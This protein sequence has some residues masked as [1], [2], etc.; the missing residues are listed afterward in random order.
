MSLIVCLASPESPHSNIRIEM[1]IL[2]NCPST[3][4]KPFVQHQAIYMISEPSAP[5]SFWCSCFVSSTANVRLT[6]ACTLIPATT[7]QTDPSVSS[8]VWRPLVSTCLTP[9][10]P[11]PSLPHHDLFPIVSVFLVLTHDP[12]WL[13]YNRSSHRNS[14]N[15]CLC[16]QRRR[17]LWREVRRLQ[18]KQWA[19][20][21][22]AD[23]IVGVA[24][25]FRNWWYAMESQTQ[26]QLLSCVSATTYVFVW[27]K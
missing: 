17:Q 1:I 16:C 7:F 22:F 6:V 15:S 4:S 13:R 12:K 23:K 3:R 25:L 20:S 11:F 10:S 18:L 21:N 9:A 26:I 19:H 8:D 14:N 27:G 2:V 24:F 5:C